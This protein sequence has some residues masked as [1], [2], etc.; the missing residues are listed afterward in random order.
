MF[1]RIFANLLHEVLN[2]LPMQLLLDEFFGIGIDNDR[3]TKPFQF[4]DAIH[5]VIDVGYVD[6]PQRTDD[7]RGR[8]IQTIRRAQTQRKIDAVFEVNAGFLL[9]SAFS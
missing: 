4:I 5:K 8:F 6:V 2:S 9:L 7:F 3:L 1:F